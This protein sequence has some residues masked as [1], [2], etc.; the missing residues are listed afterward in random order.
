MNQ[1]LRNFV[2][3]LLNDDNGNGISETSWNDLHDLLQSMGEFEFAGELA[4]IVDACDGRYYIPIDMSTEYT[5][6]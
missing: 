4:R 1:E 3:G 6:T 5:W 2:L